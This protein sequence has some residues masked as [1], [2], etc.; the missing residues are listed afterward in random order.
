MDRLYSQF[1]A[2]SVGVALLLLR[3]VDGM[4]LFAEGSRLFVPAATPSADAIPLLLGVVLIGSAIMLM[5]GLRT[6]LAG[7]AAA[8]CTIGSAV[9]AGLY[10]DQSQGEPAAWLFMFMLVFAMS[11]ALALT[12]PGGYSLDARLSG[13]KRITL[14]AGTGRGSSTTKEGR[15]R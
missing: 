8:V 12:G 2:G 15:V 5:L 4:G 6:S 3:L 9:Y 11:G 10:T 7:G 14:S 13:W 1:P